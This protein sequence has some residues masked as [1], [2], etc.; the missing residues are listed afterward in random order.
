VREWLD[1]P[2]DAERVREQFAELHHDLRRGAAQQIAD[3]LL[4]ELGHAGGR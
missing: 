2:A 4:S 3:I 1:H